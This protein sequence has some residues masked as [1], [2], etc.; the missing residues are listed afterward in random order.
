M[1]NSPKTTYYDAPIILDASA[2]GI[3]LRDT[4]D[5]VIRRLGGPDKRVLVTSS[6]S[7]HPYAPITRFQYG[8]LRILVSNRYEV[9]QIAVVQG[10]KGL[11]EEGIGIGTPAYRINKILGD[12]S[13]I[14][15]LSGEK[16][17]SYKGKPW[18]SFAFEK[19]ESGVLK[20]KA[21]IITDLT[22]A[23]DPEDLM[24]RGQIETKKRKP[25]RFKAPTRWAN[26][27]DD[28]SE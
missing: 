18:T 13:E 14:Y 6:T 20:V 15:D 2:G 3:I 4:G 28:D 12:A 1:N 8:P 9:F 17:L 21:I 25:L 23:R 22:P 7:T 24:P 11:S 5:E 16:L 27:P 10:Y 19:D 26:I